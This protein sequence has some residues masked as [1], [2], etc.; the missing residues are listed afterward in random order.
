MIEPTQQQIDAIG[1]DV[2]AGT[3]NFVA[4]GAFGVALLIFS[5]STAGLV[6]GWIMAAGALSRCFT[7][8]YKLSENW[9]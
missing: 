1:H 2:T 4:F 7:A 9:A 5:K 8:L 3:L 6:L